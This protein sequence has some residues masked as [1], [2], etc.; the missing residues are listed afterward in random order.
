MNF[1]KQMEE[2][3]KSLVSHVERHGVLLGVSDLVLGLKRISTGLGQRKPVERVLFVDSHG[4]CKNYNSKYLREMMNIEEE[5][6]LVI[7]RREGEELK[8]EASEIVKNWCDVH[9]SGDDYL[10]RSSA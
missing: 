8:A 7:L 1:G 6:L 5:T 2:L 9:F 10:F 3:D 4:R